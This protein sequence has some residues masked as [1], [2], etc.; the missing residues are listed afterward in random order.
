[1][2]I[3][4]GRKFLWEDVFGGKHICR[5]EFLVGRY[6]KVEDFREK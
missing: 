5:M 2:E 6:L 3:S 4:C 1:M